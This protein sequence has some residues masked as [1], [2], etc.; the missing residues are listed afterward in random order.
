M[1]LVLDA[2]T[3]AR[4]EVGLAQRTELLNALLADLYGEQRLL[5]EGVIP[6]AVVFGHSGYTRPVA[7]ARG[8]R[9][10]PADPLGTDL[11]RDAAGEWRVLDRPRPGALRAS[12]T[13]WRT[14]GCISRVLPE[15]YRGGR[16]APHGAVLLGAPLGAAAGRAGARWPTRA[17]SCCR[18]VRTPRP[19]TTRRSSPTSSA[20]RSCRASDLVV[21]DGWVWMKP[22]GFPQHEPHE[23]VDVILRR[24]DAEWCDPLELRGGLAARRR[25]A[26]RGRAPRPR[27]TRQRPRRRRAREPRP[28]AVHAG[29]VRAR[30]SASS[31]ACRRVPTWWCGDPEG[32]GDGARGGRSGPERVHRPPD[33]RPRGG[34]R[35][36]RPRA[37][38]A[39][40]SSRHRT[41]SSVRS[42]C[43]CRRRPRGA[44][45]AARRVGRTPTRSCCAHSPC[46][47]ASIY[48]P[49]VGG[50]ATLVDDRKAA[51]STKDVWVLKS[52][53]RRSGPGPR[54]GRCRCRWRA[55]C[56]CCRRARSRTCS[57]RAAT[58]SGP[59]TSSVS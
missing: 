49:L 42:G 6:S 31:C 54:R 59:K 58:P 36:T 18:P 44:T 12:A 20:S 7:R 9:P 3:W 46:A 45:P 11:G 41:G 39:I 50:L 21:R 2:A 47:T 5:A 52:A 23:R 28:A 30:C 17:W 32:L 33:R 57:G 53:A 43:R 48:R 22:A 16:P 10:A 51:P 4:L 29:G 25:R 15:L 19:R 14:G 1:P 26:H 13:R 40:G 27:A 24:V 56:P 8:V 34:P 38:C 37:S 55:P 35:R